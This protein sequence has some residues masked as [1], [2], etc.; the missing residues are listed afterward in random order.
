MLSLRENAL[1][2]LNGEQPDFYGDFMEAL[3]WVPD[4]VRARD[5]IPQDGKEHKDSWGTVKVF[6]PDSPGAHPHI[7][8]ENVVIPD[9]EE[10]EKYLKV[11][12]IEDLDWS[13]SR[14]VA[15]AI[16]RGQRF[17]AMFM[18]AG[19]FERS[20]FLMGME[21]A[22][23]NYLEYPEEMEEL[24]SVIADFKIR[25]I[26]IAAEEFSPDVIFYQDDWGSKQNLFLPPDTWREIIKPIQ[27]R[28][29]K[30]IHDAGALYVHH[31]DCICEPI[32][33]DMIELGVDIWQGVIPQN[34]IVAI[35]KKTA[36]KLPMIGGIDVPAIDLE[37]L[38]EEIIRGE[39]RRAIDTYC[40]AGKFFP[41]MP[42]GMCFVKRNDQIARDE[43]KSYGRIW[44]EQHL[45]K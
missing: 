29:S 23:C 19:L 16:D 12:Q 17:S 21:D 26:E 4:P 13:K 41:G 27:M 5:A 8:D 9:I 37:G 24:L 38:D 32:V 22:F 20:H 6:L 14:E 45:I 40:P 11:P 42:S 34:D 43:L 39:V 25:Q 36:G 10:W 3:S 31:A 44:A 30:A 28:I 1:A 33:E 18:A 2:I 7:T 35:Q 15:A